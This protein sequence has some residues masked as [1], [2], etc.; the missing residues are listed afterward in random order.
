MMRVVQRGPSVAEDPD[1]Q[2][3]AAGQNT[4]SHPIRTGG[5]PAE[6][7]EA[8]KP[9]PMDRDDRRVMAGRDLDAP[10]GQQPPRVAPRQHEFAAALQRDERQD[11]GRET[12]RRFPQHGA[13]RRETRPHGVQD[14]AVRQALPSAR[15]RARTAR[16]A[17]TCCR[18]RPGRRARGQ[19][20]LAPAPA[21]LRA[22]RRPCVRPG[23][24]TKRSTS[25]MRC[26]D[27]ARMPLTAGPTFSRAK[28][29]MAW[30]KMTPK[31]C[32][33]T[34]HPMMS[35]V[36]GQVCS[37]GGLDRPPGRRRRPAGR[38]RQHRRRTAP[39][40]RC[41][42]WS[43]RRAGTRACRVRR[44]PAARWCRA[45]PRPAGPRWRNP[46]RR[47]RIPARTPAPAQTSARKPIRAAT[48]A[49]RLGVATPGRATQ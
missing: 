23:W 7:P 9:E 24:Q 15:G 36:S 46:R 41:W 19:A 22:R 2:A 20:I 3:L 1:P 47:P 33:S 4:A 45:A 5:V 10:R 13:A 11:Q 49:S 42:P 30:A 29:G 38:R 26:P 48:L 37:P 6:H 43:A 8:Q 27:R 31:P 25:A 44:R 28:G 40:P 34:L 35:S 18:A 16:S 32:G 14:G 17:R 39:S 21:R 12:S